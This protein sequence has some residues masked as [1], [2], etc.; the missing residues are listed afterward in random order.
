MKW[1]EVTVT[2][3]VNAPTA[4]GAL[5]HLEGAF[6]NALRQDGEARVLMLDARERK[7]T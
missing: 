5:D 3:L 1:W 2:V 4:A 6:E 7:L